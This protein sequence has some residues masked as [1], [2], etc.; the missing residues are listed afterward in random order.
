MSR[1]RKRRNLK[2]FLQVRN[3]SFFRGKKFSGWSKTQTG[4]GLLFR[5]HVQAS[6][7][8]CTCMHIE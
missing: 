6:D 3:F 7:A 5:V 8:G 4:P 1:N 2:R